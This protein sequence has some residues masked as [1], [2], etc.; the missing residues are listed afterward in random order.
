MSFKKF[1]L[2]TVAAAATLGAGSALAQDKTVGQILAGQSR[3]ATLVAAATAAGLLDTLNG[4]DAITV[5]APTDEAFARL[6]AGTVEELLRPENKAQLEQLLKRHVVAGNLSSDQLKRQR[7]LTSVGGD[8]LPVRLV[9]GRLRVAQ[10]RVVGSELTASNGGVLTLD[11][12]L[13]Q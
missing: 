2:A 4:S 11:A 10:A 6:P 3:F 7:E 8:A 9:N 13:T 1:I 12:V 5:L